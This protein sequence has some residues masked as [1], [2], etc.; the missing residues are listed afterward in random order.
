MKQQKQKNNVCH[1]N[2]RTPTVSPSHIAV[3]LIHSALALLKI[4]VE[5]PL[6]Y[7]T[8]PMIKDP[9]DHHPLRLDPISIEALLHLSIFGVLVFSLSAFLLFP[10]KVP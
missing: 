8:L 1:T 3:L 2:K 6:C 7:L 9:V 4:F 5:N 10:S